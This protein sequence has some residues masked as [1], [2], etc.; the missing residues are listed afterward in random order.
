MAAVRSSASSLARK[1]IVV[2]DGQSFISDNNDHVEFRELGKLLALTI[3]RGA[4]R[5]P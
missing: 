3:I 4:E 1:L 2:I 5:V